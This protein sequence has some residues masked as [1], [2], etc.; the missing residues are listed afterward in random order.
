[1]CALGRYCLYCYRIV[2]IL[3]CG[4]KV[5]NPWWWEARGLGKFRETQI[6]SFIT[7]NLLSV[8]Q[9]GS[10]TS[11][12]LERRGRYRRRCRSQHRDGKLRPDRPIRR[13]YVESREFKLIHLTLSRLSGTYAPAAN[14]R[15]DSDRHATA[16]C[17]TNRLLP[18]PRRR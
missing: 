11:V 16:Y 17:T 2:K 15:V 10:A 5:W 1:M 12:S 6:S 7:S 9:N 14:R 3:E 18:N 4:R 13:V 8:Q